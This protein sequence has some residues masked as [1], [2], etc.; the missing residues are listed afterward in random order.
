MLIWKRHLLT[1]FWLS[2]ISLLC[3]AFIFYT[4]I[5]H[6][7]HAIK[8][9]SS[10]VTSL[11]SLKLSLLYYVSQIALKAEF[12][13][14]QLVAIATTITLFSMQSRRE[15][16]LLQASGLSL[17]SLTAPLITSGCIITLILYANFQWLHPICEKISITK[18][19]LDQGIS[20]EHQEKIPALYLKDLSVLLY[21]SIDQRL[22]TLNNVFW[23]QNSKTIYSIEKLAFS[24][25][26]LPIGL[27]VI[28]F[29]ENDSGDTS[30]SQFFD[31]KEFPEIEFGFYDNPFSKIFSAGGKNRLSEFYKAI[32]WN[33]SGIGLKT[34]IPQ[35]ILSLLS[36]FYYMLIAPLACISAI[37][38]SAYLCLRFSRTP[39]ATLAYLIPLGVM[40][41]FFV[42]LKAGIVLTNSSVLPTFPVLVTPLIVLAIVTHYAYAN[43]Q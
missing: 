41:I 17:K 20:R 21:S 11:D 24:T 33:A 14:P 39:S 7:L 9:S 34:T 8:G 31:M 12:L 40:N 23:I 22:L 26:S 6:S 36:Q 38:I 28:E 3:L 43:L 18:E 37:I 42:F 32:P 25:P 13:L 35:R 4:S 2:L 15:V 27:N 29:S 30:F 5:H 19:Y 10:S 1:R 16:L